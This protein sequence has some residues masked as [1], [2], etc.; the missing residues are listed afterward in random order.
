MCCGASDQRLV[1][2]RLDGDGLLHQAVE[3]LASTSGL[4]A[5]EA[6]GE[7]V[8]VG[9]E[10]LV[11]DGS[12]MR[13]QYPALQQR[14]RVRRKRLGLG[15]SLHQILQVLSVTLFEKTPIVR[16]FHDIDSKDPHPSISN[17]LILFDL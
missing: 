13:T 11:A 15:P 2:H 4:A 6:E 3:E 12:L 1:G 5:V 16:A 7:F 8:E 17:Q 9:V 10:M 14:S